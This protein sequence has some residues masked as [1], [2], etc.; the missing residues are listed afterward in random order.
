[1]EGGDAPILILHG[2]ADETVAYSEALDLEADAVAK[3]I[4]YS[5][6]T[7]RGA[8]HG[9]SEVNPYDNTVDGVSVFE[10]TLDFIEAHVR[11]DAPRYEV[12]S[13]TSGA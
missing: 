3:N 8:G 1:M 2:D 11:D 6:Y 10:L 9:W 5:F 4:R 12:R 13:I 7:V